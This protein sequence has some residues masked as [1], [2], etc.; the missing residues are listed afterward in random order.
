MRNLIKWTIVISG[1]V[2]KLS[3]QGYDVSLHYYVEYE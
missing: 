2:P 1:I 3:Q